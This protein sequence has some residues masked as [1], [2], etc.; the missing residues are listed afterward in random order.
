MDAGG[1]TPSNAT[2]PSMPARESHKN[3][4]PIVRPD[5]RPSIHICAGRR[6]GA[7]AKRRATY[8]VSAI[9][10]ATAMPYD[11]TMTARFTFVC[12][13]R[14]ARGFTGISALMDAARFPPIAGEALDGTPF[15][16]PRDL[17]AARTVAFVAF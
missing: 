15:V 6:S 13:V 5:G 3:H 7:E 14:V 17:A 11:P 16:A 1:F 10:P 9:A 12:T 8:A 2:P 4:L